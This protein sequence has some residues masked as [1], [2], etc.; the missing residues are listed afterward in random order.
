MKMIKMVSPDGRA[1]VLCHPGSYENMI[2][3]GYTE[4]KPTI[5]E[6]KADG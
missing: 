5:K 3:A 2:T 6:G 4:A 1:T